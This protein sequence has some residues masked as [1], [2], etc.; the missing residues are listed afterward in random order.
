M[1]V[2]INAAVAGLAGDTRGTLTEMNALTGVTG[3]RFFNSTY[4]HP[5]IWIVDRWWPVGVPDSRYGFSMTDEFH[6]AVG[7]PWTALGT[8]N[9]GTGTTGM[10]G[11]WSL[12]QATASQ[13]SGIVQTFETMLLGSYDLYIEGIIKTSTLATAGEDYVLTFGLNDLLNFDANGD[14]VGDGVYFQ[15]DRA[16]TGDFWGT[17]TVNNTTTTANTSA[18]AVA[19]STKYRLGIVVSGSTSVKFYV[20]GV[21]TAVTHTTNIPN[22]AGRMAAMAFRIDKTAGTGANTAEIDHLSVYGFF[23]SAR[24]A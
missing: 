9:N 16:V 10:Y 15:Y 7:V 14:P 22:A 12:S 4:N 3:Q 23:S 20:N 19:A 2:A 17:R 1:S 6:G 18:I 5:F 24:V 13:R 8:V 21:Q 11:S